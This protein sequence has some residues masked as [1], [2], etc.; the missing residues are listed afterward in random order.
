MHNTLVL[1]PSCYCHE[2]LLV[3]GASGRL[4]DA[5]L[6]LDGWVPRHR[7]EAAVRDAGT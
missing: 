3:R 7:G 1:F 4:E 5:R 6:T 2:M